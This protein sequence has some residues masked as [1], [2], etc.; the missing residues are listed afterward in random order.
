[1]ISPFLASCPQKT[2]KKQVSE[3]AKRVEASKSTSK[4][5]WM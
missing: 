5:V 3:R 2:K 4:K 1:M